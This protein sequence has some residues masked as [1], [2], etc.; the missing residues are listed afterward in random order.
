MEWKRSVMMGALIAVL[1]SA[2][3]LLAQTPDATLAT[4]ALSP[5]TRALL[6]QEMQALAEAMGRIHRAMVTGAHRAVAT[7]AKAIHDSFVLAQELS[8]SQ[9]QEIQTALPPAFVSA[10]RD[11][12]ELSAKLVDAAMQE[13]APLER[14]WFDEVTRACLGCHQTFAAKRFPGLLVGESEQ[15]QGADSH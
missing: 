13:D 15:K 14:F 5:P 8:K 9:R 10:D 1:G 2:N 4:E 7:E 11:F 3:S 6:I 12:H